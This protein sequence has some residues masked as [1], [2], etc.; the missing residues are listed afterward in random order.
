MR[1]PLTLTQGQPPV[2]EDLSKFPFKVRERLAKIHEIVR[3]VRNE[4]AA[5][6]KQYY[7]QTAT[8]APFKPGD[9][10]FLYQPQG[11]PGQSPKLTSPW[12][13]P[14]TVLNIINDCNAR[15]RKD[16]HPYSLSIVHIDRLISYPG[17]GTDIVAA[18]LTYV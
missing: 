13:G 8:L 7:D 3:S 4:A 18:W 9:K 16:T 6:M 5:K 12:R 11:K 2:T 15:I 10:V 14:Y 1:T 17:D